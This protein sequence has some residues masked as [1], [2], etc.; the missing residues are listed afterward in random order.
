MQTGWLE[1]DIL[2]WHP[3]PEPQICVATP[4]ATPHFPERDFSENSRKTRHFL[5]I[6]KKNHLSMLLS[7]HHE[8]SSGWN[9]SGTFARRAETNKSQSFEIFSHK[10]EK[11]LVS[12]KPRIFL[13]FSFLR[14]NDRSSFFCFFLPFGSNFFLFALFPFSIFF[15]FRLRLIKDMV[16]R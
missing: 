7:C 10:I 13:N 8:T 2:F 1:T 5:L 6:R 15:D 16:S 12:K 4:L 9:L 11:K 14:K 3:K